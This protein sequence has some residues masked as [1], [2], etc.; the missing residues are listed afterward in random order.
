MAPRFGPAQQNRARS[1]TRLKDLHILARGCHG[2][3]LPRVT[4]LVRTRRGSFS[5]AES[6][7]NPHMHSLQNEAPFGGRGPG[8]ASAP[9]GNHGLGYAFPSGLV[10][11]GGWSVWEG[12][13]NAGPFG[14]FVIEPTAEGSVCRHRTPPDMAPCRSSPPIDHKPC[15]LRWQSTTPP[16][17][18]S[19]NFGPLPP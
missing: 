12:A 7:P 19:L 15:L 13:S 1:E 14:R 6:K 4:G 18:F 10:R 8:V 11:P 17:D 5:R 2:T 16:G 9:L 3:W